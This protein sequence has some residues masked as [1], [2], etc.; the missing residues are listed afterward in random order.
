MKLNF[1]TAV[2]ELTSV[3]LI[4]RYPVVVRDRYGHQE[5]GRV[6]IEVLHA[7]SEAACE[8]QV[9]PALRL[10]LFSQPRSRLAS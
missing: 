9:K 2:R 1:D 8:G 5:V 4:V 3:G 7:Q 6:L 10:R